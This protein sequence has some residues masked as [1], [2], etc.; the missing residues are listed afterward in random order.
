MRKIVLPALEVLLLSLLFCWLIINDY[1]YQLQ[2]ESILKTIDECVVYLFVPNSKVMNELENELKEKGYI[3][4][5]KASK[6]TEVVKQMV[7]NYD[8]ANLG[9]TVN[10][11]SLPN[12]IEFRLDSA[13]IDTIKFKELS[14]FLQEKEKLFTYYLPKEEIEQSLALNVRTTVFR[15]IYR[16]G[17][18]LI[19]LVLSCLM[20]ALWIKRYVDTTDGEEPLLKEKK[21]ITRFGIHVVILSVIPALLLSLIWYITMRYGL[22]TYLLKPIELL[23]LVA[24]V[25][26]GSIISWLS[27]G[28]GD[29]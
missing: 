10:I 20:N 29:K 2:R 24:A 28:R 9:Q 13:L 18:L 25:L 6:N 1:N 17:G 15:L 26:I 14:D 16:I 19:T 11:S 12:L 23:A 3:R 4:E 5:L 27:N 7:E 21:K 22:H 8:L